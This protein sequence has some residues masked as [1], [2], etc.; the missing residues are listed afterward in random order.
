MYPIKLFQAGKATFCEWRF[1]NGQPFGRILN[2]GA[3][4]F[5]GSAFCS[6]EEA[7]L[8]C[9]RA[10]EKDASLIFY[11]VQG[12]DIIAAIQDDAYHKAK[13][14]K[15]GRIYAAVSTAIVMVLASGVSFMIMPFQVMIYDALFIGAMGVF[16]LLLY[17]IGG[18][19]N[20]EAVV[21]III[22]LVL[23]SAAVPLVTKI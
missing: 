6:L 12:D 22:L 16:Y 1:E 18:R 17:S 14:T 19:W 13:E 20:L 8:F 15:E 4:V 9:E 7:K 10:L 5:L 23:L 3:G 11:I 2:Q 21:A